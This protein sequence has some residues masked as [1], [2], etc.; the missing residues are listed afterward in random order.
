MDNKL[1]K[2][3]DFL[4]EI[5][6][7]KH[8]FRQ[9]LLPKDCRRENDAEH[10][11]HLCMYAVVLEEYA[12][13]GCDLLRC[14]KMMLMHDLVE[15]YAGDT[16]LYDV[17]GNKTKAKREQEAADKLYSMLGEQGEELKSYWLEFEANETAEAKFANALD[18]LQ[19]IMLNY[20][21]R[22]EKWLVNHVTKAEV[23]ERG[24]K[25]TKDADPRLREFVMSII[26]ESVEKGYLLP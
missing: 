12:P 17:E 4:R 15:I 2:Q 5:D 19:P 23:V 3:I 16:Y 20:F 26:D 10:S 14:I 25:L 7:L 9:S 11:W 22:G 13:E 18:R 21:T 1:I 8:I 6:N 24:S